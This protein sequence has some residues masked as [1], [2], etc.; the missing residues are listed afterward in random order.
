MTIT[1][2]FLYRKLNMIFYI[3]LPLFRFYAM[4]Q[5]LN[6]PEVATHPNT[7]FLFSSLYPINISLLASDS[8]ARAFLA[9]SFF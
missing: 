4:I 6:Y 1:A 3:S 8:I 7:C 9:V 2:M 5:T